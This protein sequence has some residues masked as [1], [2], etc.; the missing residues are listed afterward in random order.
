MP[1]SVSAATA[2][3]PVSR[4]DP[5]RPAS[6]PPRLVDDQLTNVMNTESRALAAAVKAEWTQLAY[7][8]VTRAAIALR[9][10][11]NTDITRAAPEKR[12]PALVEAAWT[13]LPAELPQLLMNPDMCTL[14]GVEGTLPD[15]LREAVLRAVDDQITRDVSARP[16]SEQ[17]AAEARAFIQRAL[18]LPM[19]RVLG[20]P[21]VSK[22]FEALYSGT[23]SVPT[24]DAV[25]NRAA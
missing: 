16:D 14:Y 19:P 12:W 3:L 21:L 10:E 5:T 23:F 25:R 20:T 15:A 4:V 17:V 6:A 2:P 24:P 22:L 9:D 8:W 7:R 11:R 1:R 13:F 18:A